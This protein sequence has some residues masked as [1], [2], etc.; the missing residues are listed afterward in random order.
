MGKP[1]LRTRFVEILSCLALLGKD[2]GVVDEEMSCSTA[3]R[4]RRTTVIS[5]IDKSC[6][7]SGSLPFDNFTLR[8]GQRVRK[9]DGAADTIASSSCK[10][11]ERAK[12]NLT[13]LR[14]SSCVTYPSRMSPQ[15]SSRRRF[16]GACSKVARCMVKCGV[17]QSVTRRDMQRRHQTLERTSLSRSF[18]NTSLHEDT[19]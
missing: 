10:T 12:V 13:M 5:Y 17:S 2:A 1:K 3:S 6:W 15:D 8:A 9:I 14:I 16:L 11:S 18:L 19:L 7:A 4:W